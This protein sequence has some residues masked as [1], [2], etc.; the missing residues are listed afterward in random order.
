MAT[1][2]TTVTPT[3]PFFALNPHFGL[4]L[5]V[6][7]LFTLQGY[8]AGKTRLHNAW[9]HRA[10]VVWGLRASFNTRN[11]LQVDPGLA[12]DGLGRELH[13]DTAQ[14][15]DLARWYSAAVAEQRPNLPPVVGGRVN[16]QLHVVI[17]FKAC[18]S[19]AVPAITDGCNTGPA[20]AAYSRIT[21][22]ARLELRLGAAPTPD[23]PYHRLRVL[24]G[25]EAG[26]ATDA[27]VIA[28]RN[29]VLG[30]PAPQQPAA[31][32]AALRELA[33]EDVMDI[34]PAQGAT[35]P[36]YPVAEPG[37][38][39]LANVSAELQTSGTAPAGY[40]VL[41]P[42]VT[43]TT[44]PKVVNSVRPSHVATSTLQELLC[45]PSG[46]TA[47]A[48]VPPGPVDAGG[49]RVDPATVQLTG[50][51]LRFTT[52]TALVPAS[53]DREAFVVTTFLGTGWA[54]VDVKTASLDA[55]RTGVTLE[56]KETPVVGSWLRLIVSGT[57]ARPLL[58]EVGT[59]LVPLA[60]PVAGPAGTRV[61][62]NDFL[63]FWKVS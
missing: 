24:F 23:A 14:C 36:S 33:A 1:E 13:V 55:A 2:T 8:A 4:L 56:L 62:G 45:G 17:C 40:T 19:K 51:T 31:W 20:G 59:D 30:L 32:L 15:L 53:V 12:V 27:V 26:T 9:L 46:T 7:D 44:T 39:V 35:N 38:V 58:G 11:E 25:L 50:T 63:H 34:T 41:V 28:R 52:T 21:E 18:L 43:D 60:G 37:C 47:G 48:P 29:A 6:E 49:P 54:G 3:N 57:G 22:E 42:G 16:V 61:Q 5:G 10:G